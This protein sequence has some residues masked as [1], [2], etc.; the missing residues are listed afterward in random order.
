MFPLSDS[1]RALERIAREAGAAAKL[2]GSGGAVIG[3][4]RDEASWRP[5]ER[6]FAA[7]G[8]AAARARVAEPS[9]SSAP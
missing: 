2:C 8:F 7:S 5:L 3:V 6:A 4:L 1:D 9:D